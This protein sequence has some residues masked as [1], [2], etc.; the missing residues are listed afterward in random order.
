MKK[1]GLVFIAVIFFYGTAWAG[2]PD[3]VEIEKSVNELVQ[4]GFVKKINYQLNEVF[5]VRKLWERTTY[6]D[7][8]LIGAF[9]GVY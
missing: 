7:K 5:V 2:E 1:A 9:L 8:K 3:F 4:V 6:D